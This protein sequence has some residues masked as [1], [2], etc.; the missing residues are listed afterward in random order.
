VAALVFVEDFCLISI[1][2]DKKEFG[3]VVE[4]WRAGIGEKLRKG[5]R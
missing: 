3:S 4:E 5:R 1:Y 2:T